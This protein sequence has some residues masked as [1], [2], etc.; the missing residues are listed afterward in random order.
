MIHYDLLSISM[1]HIC[2]CTLYLNYILI[3]PCT[4]YSHCLLSLYMYIPIYMHQFEFNCTCDPPVMLYSFADS[5]SFINKF[6]FTL[7]VLCRLFTV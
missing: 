4:V 2:T 7:Q 6:I 5:Q 1:L 3:V